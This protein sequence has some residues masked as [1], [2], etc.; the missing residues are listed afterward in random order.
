MTFTEEFNQAIINYCNA[1]DKRVFFDSLP[2]NIHGSLVRHLNSD[3]VDET[4]FSAAC[5]TGF[6]PLKYFPFVGDKLFLK[7]IEH[8]G[9]EKTAEILIKT[10]K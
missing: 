8:L 1:E 10:A 9:A 7:T 3:I 6:N 5:E 2:A 4:L